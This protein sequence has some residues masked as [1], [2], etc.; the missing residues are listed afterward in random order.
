[1]RQDEFL[2]A[3]EVNGTVSHTHEPDPNQTIVNLNIEPVRRARWS[4]YPLYTTCRCGSRISCAD[5][6]ADWH[7]I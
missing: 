2:D 1:M 5:S 4:D 3:L 6:S 7:V